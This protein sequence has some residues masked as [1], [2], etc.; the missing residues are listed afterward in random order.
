MAKPQVV[1]FCKVTVSTGYDGAATSIV[2][3]TGHGARLPSTFDFYL[4]WWN[5]TDYADPADDPN[6]EIIKVTA[7][8]TDTLTVLR[9]QDGTSASTKNTVGKTYRMVLSPV[10]ALHD[11]VYAMHLHSTVGQ[12]VISSATVCKFNPFSGNTICINGRMETIPVGGVSFSNTGLVSSTLY[13]AYAFMSGGA[14]AGEFSTTARAADTTTGVEIK[15]G[16]S[17]RSL[18]GMVFT[19]ASGQFERSLG[20]A[21][22]ASWANRQL[23]GSLSTHTGS[24]PTTSSITPVEI[25]SLARAEFLIWGGSH[26]MLTVAASIDIAGGASRG[27]TLGIQVESG[28]IS[29]APIAQGNNGSASTGRD[30]AMVRF[31]HDGLSE[32]HHYVTPVFAVG[33]AS[34]TAT[35]VNG[36]IYGMAE[37]TI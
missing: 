18:V 19:S 35:A 2:L 4:V 25:S 31:A 17:T 14:M 20:K 23:V 7:R 29:G 9:G 30:T 12:F 8:S 10:K 37:V 15:S 32:G 1:N 11:D 24:D 36:S 5:V 6:V 28:A 21:N 3:T 26:A 27:W 22:V 33:N 13:Y 16:D 34:W